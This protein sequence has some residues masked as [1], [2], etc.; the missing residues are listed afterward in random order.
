[1]NALDAFDINCIVSTAMMRERIIELQYNGYYVE[2]LAPTTDGKCQ[3]VAKVLRPDMRPQM[4]SDIDMRG[5]WLRRSQVV[6]L[7]AEERK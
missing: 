1:M 4:W 5:F 2:S 3:I 7:K 6:K